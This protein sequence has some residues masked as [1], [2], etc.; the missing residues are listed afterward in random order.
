M[1]CSAETIPKPKKKYSLRIDPTRVKSHKVKMS[2]HLLPY[3]K[4]KK[5]KTGKKKNPSLELRVKFT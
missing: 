2:V 3:L 1:D 4:K 5:K